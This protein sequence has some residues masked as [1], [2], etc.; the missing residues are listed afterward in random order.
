MES[1]KKYWNIFMWPMFFWGHYLITIK[2]D[3]GKFSLQCENDSP[4]QLRTK[5]VVYSNSSLEL[6]IEKKYATDLIPA[7]SYKK[8]FVF[9]VGLTLKHITNCSLKLAKVFSQ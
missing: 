6:R 2:W 9:L 5:K 4:L 3:W 1:V 7:K 8:C